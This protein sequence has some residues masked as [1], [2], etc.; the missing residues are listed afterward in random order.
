MREPAPPIPFGEVDEHAEQVMVPMRDGVRLATDIYLCKTPSAPVVLIRLPYDKTAP[1]AFVPQIARYVVDHGYHFVAQDTRGKIRSEGETFAF[2]FEVQDGADT[3][4]WIE[5]RS[6]CDGS[7]V[8]FGESYYGFTQWAAAASGHP[9]LKAI[10]PLLTSTEIG[11]DWMYHQGVFCL[12]TVLGWGTDTW[13]DNPLYEIPHDHDWMRRPLADATPA[14]LGGRRSGSLDGWRTKP[15]NDPFWTRGIFGDVD[16]L[17][18]RI[19]ALHT[20]GWW[21]VFRRGQLRDFHT[22]ARNGAP[23]QHLRFEAIDHF[24]DQLLPDG[25]VQDPAFVDSPAEIEAMMPRHLDPALQFFDHYVR[26]IGEAPPT[27]R[28]Q[29][30]NAEMRESATWPPAGCR[31]LELFLGDAGAAS[32]GPEGGALLE[33]SE[34]SDGAVH[35]MHDPSDPVP[36]T[37]ADAWR[38]LLGLPDER[39]VE[40]RNDVITFS[41]DPVGE[42]LDIVGS[43]SASLFVKAASRS[44]HVMAKLVDVFPDGAARRITEGACLASDAVDGQLVSVDL[45]DIGYRLEAGHRLRLEVASSDFPRYMLHPGSDEDP[46]AASGGE[47]VEQQ[48]SVGGSTDSRLKIHVLGK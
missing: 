1:F 43:V 37:V 41:A 3:L 28:W 22:A 21:D 47:P 13:I 42:P 5:S 35:W 30:S 23:G 9:A 15:P 4:E 17:G 34:G 26:G 20:G 46:W 11:T 12:E 14:I 48:V 32:A 25:G 10:A 29:L 44:T 33:H 6:W 19:P 16:P 40:R 7:V 24:S 2:V 36:T 31:T 39:E 45:S 18:L 27:V 8:M 38:P